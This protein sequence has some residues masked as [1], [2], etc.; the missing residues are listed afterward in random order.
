[1]ADIILHHYPL[2]PYSE[3]IRLA[4]GLKRLAWRSVIIPVTTPRPD[5]MPMTGGYRRTPVMQ[6]GADIYC[7]TQLILRTLER[8][9]PEPSLFPQG[10]QGVATALA[11][12]WDKSTFVPAVGIVASLRQDLFTPEFAEERRGF[13]GGIDLTQMAPDLPLFVQ[14]MCAHL[15]WLTSM[16][17]DGRPFMLGAQPSAADLTAYHTIWF[18][19]QNG[20]PKAEAMLPLGA[21]RAWFDRVS[22]IG[23]GTEQEMSA[24]DA[25][26]VAKH[27]KPAQPDIPTD[28]DPSGYKPG[29][30]VSVTPDDMGRDPVTGTLVAADAQEIVIRRSDS[31]VGEVNVHFPRAGFDVKPA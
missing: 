17:A 26:T 4:L 22:A 16:F 27:A 30:Q 18:I 29:Q 2:S 7:D 20:G 10:T 15:G 25:L 11:W 23:H 28:G 13:L 21:L 19:R 9:H 31:K 24:A 8:L 5:L 1:M 12:W 6:V 14:R 3:K